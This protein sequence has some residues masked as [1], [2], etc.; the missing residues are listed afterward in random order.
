[1]KLVERDDGPRSRFDPEKLRRV[2]TVRHREDAGRIALKKQAW[3]E[4]THCLEYDRLSATCQDFRA[5]EDFADD[6]L[7]PAEAHALFGFDERPIDENRMLQH[8]VQDLVV[9][10]VRPE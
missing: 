5:L 8:R 4:T 7:R 1:M 3:I 9:G 6:L 2:A 10:D